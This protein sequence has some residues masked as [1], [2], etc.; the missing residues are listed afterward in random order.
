[1]LASVRNT[2]G[3]IVSDYSPEAKQV[4]DP[5]AAYLTQ[6][7][8]EGVINYGSAAGVRAR[9][10]TAP[11]A[12]KT[13]TSHD[14]WFAGYTSNLICI[15][16]VGNDDYTDVKIEGAHAAA[17]IWA[18]F[19]KSAIKLPQYSDVKSFSPPEGVSVAQI[20]R[21]TGLLAD[22]SCSTHTVNVAFL[23]GTVP[24]GSCSQMNENPQNFFQKL[25]GL[26]GHAPVSPSAPAAPTP[27]GTAPPP[28]PTSASP[29]S[30]A[31]PQPTQPEQPK[32]K[33]NIFQKIFGGGNDNDNKQP[34]PGQS[35]Q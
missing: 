6:S 8:L 16:W 23:D 9:G 26:G 30:P 1:M 3:D 12:G 20:D 21:D 31:T 18:E 2:N 14:A 22:A 33:K 10:F 4:M 27:V 7:L 5:R 15:V 35:P 17:P 25:F 28:S 13:G 29:A 34:Q 11:A 19:M 24:T 32:K